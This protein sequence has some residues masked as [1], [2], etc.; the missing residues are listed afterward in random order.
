MQAPEKGKCGVKHELVLRDSKKVWVITPLAVHSLYQIAFFSQIAFSI[1]ILSLSALFTHAHFTSGS[2][3]FGALKFNQI[4]EPISENPGR[5]QKTQVKFYSSRTISGTKFCIIQHLAREA[6]TSSMY[7][8]IS[9]SIYVYID[10]YR[11][12]TYTTI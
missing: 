1:S 10:F 11:K 3:I 12:L 8:Y 4:R 9:I 2:R 5:I 6:V 7:I